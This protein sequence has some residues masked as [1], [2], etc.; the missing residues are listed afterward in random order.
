MHTQATRMS[1]AHFLLPI[2]PPTSHPRLAPSLSLPDT[3]QAPFAHEKMRGGGGGHDWAATTVAEVMNGRS[4]LGSADHRDTN[5]N[6]ISQRGVYKAK[7]ENDW[8]IL[9]VAQTPLSC[10]FVRACSLDNN[11][12]TRPA[13]FSL[14]LSA[15]LPS[16]FLPSSP[17]Y[18]SGA[19][20]P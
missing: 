3:P 11:G 18:L 8:H 1:C 10:L 14:V 2:S 5:I 20:T 6:V 16:F 4:P 19:D 7:L 15:C 17:Q 12:T 13:L 9:A